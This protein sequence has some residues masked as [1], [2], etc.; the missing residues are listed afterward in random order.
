MLLAVW[1]ASCA[2]SESESA[3][4]VLFR[5]DGGGVS[6]DTV[7]DSPDGSKRRPSTQEDASFVPD[8]TDFSIY[9]DGPGGAVHV[10]HFQDPRRQYADWAPPTAPQGEVPGT[11]VTLN[12][13]HFS[14]WIPQDVTHVTLS[15]HPSKDAPGPR[16]G[17]V[18]SVVPTQAHARVAAELAD[19]TEPEMLTFQSVAPPD[20]TRNIVFLAGGYSAAKRQTFIDD[21]TRAVKFLRGGQASEFSTLA[22]PMNRYIGMMNVFAVWKASPQDGAEHPDPNG[23]VLEKRPNTLD[24][25]YGTTVPRMLACNRAKSLAMATYAPAADWVITLVNDPDH[26]GGAACCGVT[27]L[28][29]GKMMLQVLIHELGHAIADASDEYDYGFTEDK[30]L[31]LV[32][33]VKDVNNPPW[34]AWLNENPVPPSLKATAV[35]SYTN[36]YRPSPGDDKQTC[37]MYKSSIVRM[38]P[39]CR[40]AFIEKLFTSSGQ[41]RPVDLGAPACPLEDETL[42]VQLKSNGQTAAPASL[43]V[44]PDIRRYGTQSPFRDQDVPANG[45]NQFGPALDVSWSVTDQSGAKSIVGSGCSTVIIGDMRSTSATPVSSENIPSCYWRPPAEG[46]YSFEVL[47]HDTVHQCATCAGC[48]CDRWLR[49][50]QEIPAQ[51][52]TF[53]VK[54]VREGTVVPGE[55]VVNC[56]SRHGLGLWPTPIP[57][58]SLSTVCKVNGTCNMS[59]QSHPKTVEEIEQEQKAKDGE[60]ILAGGLGALENSASVGFWLFIVGLAMGVF[61]LLA[62]LHKTC[63]GVVEDDE[64]ADK[65]TECNG[66]LR[67]AAMFYYTIFVFLGVSI[68][69]IAAYLLWGGSELEIFGKVMYMGLL[70]YGIASFMFSFVGFKAAASRSKCQLTVVGVCLVIML[71]GLSIL[72]VVVERL[73]EHAKDTVAVVSEGPGAPGEGAAEWEAIEF[74]WFSW[75]L[76]W[77]QHLR[78][79][80]KE[81]VASQPDVI[82][83]FQTEV[84]CSGFQKACYDVTNSYCPTNCKEGN[85]AVNPCVH[86]LQKELADGFTE[87][88]AACITSL[89]SLS[90]GFLISVSL[91]ISVCGPGKREPQR[92]KAD[93]DDYRQM[94]QSP[95]FRDMSGAV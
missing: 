59:F 71:V 61:G 33:C 23:V 40:A 20:K 80:W 79:L 26:Y 9:H 77:M 50:D 88:S 78:D 47:V 49:N 38:C 35:C 75:K 16:R 51:N 64:D 72:Y 54:V 91:A 19:S 67:K 44:N 48:A 92:R 28:Y 15:D 11:L 46:D 58:E 55:T 95:N 41:P 17:Q 74:D 13:S 37:L 5:V 56:T 6:V 31:K 2:V 42:L 21:V 24:C 34:Q 12:H 52:K 30:D 27:W 1:L 18:L 57:S 29:N 22:Q 89:C 68:I 65:F 3:R 66:R 39:V 4:W 81:L 45:V 53:R 83:S 69:G 63:K 43:N 93:T 36:F 25:S 8:N 94:R 82:C 32:N 85:R 73:A 62:A 76:E 14:A 86:D 90:F 10:Q 87:V 84:G 60:D 70:F 7:L